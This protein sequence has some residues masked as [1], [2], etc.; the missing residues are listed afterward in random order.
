MDDTVQQP[1][2][3]RLVLHAGLQRK[4]INLL[5]FLFIKKRDRILLE[6]PKDLLF[7]CL[8]AKQLLMGK[9]LLVSL[10]VTD[11]L[12]GTVPI[13]DIAL[14]PLQDRPLRIHGAGQRHIPCS[15]AVVM[16]PVMLQAPYIIVRFHHIHCIPEH[17]AGSRH[18]L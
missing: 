15:I 8:H 11:Q 16:E 17:P 14:Q 1:A 12:P 13:Q 6:I 5:H 4:G 18:V 7:R 2:P 9:R 10:P 3:L